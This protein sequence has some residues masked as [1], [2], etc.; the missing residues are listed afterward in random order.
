[1]NTLH[2]FP[3][4]ISLIHRHFEKEVP[5]ISDPKHGSFDGSLDLMRLAV[6]ESLLT[7]VEAIT[8]V[9]QK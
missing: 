8:L 2:S 9:Y 6:P 4:Y 5:P 3:G 7:E 1:M